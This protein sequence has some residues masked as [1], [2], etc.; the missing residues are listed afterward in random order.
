MR[1]EKKGKFW[2]DVMNDSLSIKVSEITSLRCL[3]FAIKRSNS[4]LIVGSLSW[5][6][7]TSG[8]HAKSKEN[9][10][11]IEHLFPF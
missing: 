1:R 9:M 4:G 11:F 10:Y 3:L 8:K 7:H 6:L 2:L 5:E